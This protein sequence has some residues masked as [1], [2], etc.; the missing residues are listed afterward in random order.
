MKAERRHPARGF[1]LVELLVVITIIAVLIGLLVPAIGKVRDIA[2]RSST[3]ATFASLGTG[4]ET[5][6]ADTK[7]GGAYPPSRSDE[8]RGSSGAGGRV[9][10]PYV[11]GTRRFINGMS[12]AGLLVWAMMGADGLGTAGFRYTRSDNKQ[13]L[14][15]QDTDAGNTG[16][17]PAKSGLYALRT[18]A[19]RSPLHNRVAPYV[20]PSKISRSTAR[21]VNDDTQFLIPNE[22]AGRGEYPRDYPMF[23][24]GY[25]NPILYYRADPAGVA[26]ADE[27]TETGAK[28]GVYHHEDNGALLRDGEA[29]RL[30]LSESGEKH[31]MDWAPA[32]PPGS[33]PKGTFGYYIKDLQVTARDWPARPQSYLLISP[34][35]DGL[36]GTGDDIGNFPHNGGASGK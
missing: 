20:D 14:W 22:R 13:Q 26:M 5:Y 9:T 15:S 21:V 31:K 17:D 6:K 16:D 1:T 2:K 23:L 19:D 24:D 3:E 10:N 8:P 33:F 34:G 7:F 18:S 30:I 4:I 12:G 36:Y 28:R 25:G 29:T 27:E 32:V 35:R 11:T